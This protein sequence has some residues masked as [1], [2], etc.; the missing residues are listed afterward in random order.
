MKISLNIHILNMLNLV[1]FKIKMPLF[2]GIPKLSLYL[3]FQKIYKMSFLRI[4]KSIHMKVK[5]DE[6]FL[7]TFSFIVDGSRICIVGNFKLDIKNGLNLP[8]CFDKLWCNKKTWV[9]T[10]H[11]CFIK[12]E[13]CIKMQMV[14]SFLHEL[15]QQLA[16]KF[17]SNF[18]YQH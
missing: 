11:N 17:A 16:L 6:I 12:L 13:T 4:M 3:V 1:I 14:V 18:D 8:K 2:H 15:Q 10:I 9:H 7:S 5:L